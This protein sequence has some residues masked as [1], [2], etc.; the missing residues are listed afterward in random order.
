VNVKPDLGEL[1]PVLVPTTDAIS[2]LQVGV[3]FMQNAPEL[4]SPYL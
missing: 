3:L 2:S 4:R 1:Y